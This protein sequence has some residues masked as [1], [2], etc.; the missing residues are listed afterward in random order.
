MF[1]DVHTRVSARDVVTDA[2]IVRP[3]SGRNGPVAIERTGSGSIIKRFAAPHARSREHKYVTALLTRSGCPLR[4]H[5]A[6][7]DEKEPTDDETLAIRLVR[8]AHPLWALDFDHRGW[9]DQVAEDLGRIL[10]WLHLTGPPDWAEAASTIELRRLWLP[11]LDQFEA[12]SLAN[13]QLLRLLQESAAFQEPLIALEQR[14]S[15]NTL[16]HGDLR[17]ANILLSTDEGNGQPKIWLVDWEAAGL[18]DPN[19]DLGAIFADL[20]TRWVTSMP[21]RSDDPAGMVTGAEI[22]LEAIRS[23]ARGML[24]A[25]EATCGIESDRGLAVGYTGVSLITNALTMGDRSS[26]LM[27]HQVLL[28]QLAEHCLTASDDVARTL[29]G[30]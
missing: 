6:E 24:A 18:G 15:S 9:G 1:T 4:R 29:L 22:P 2:V 17:L 28:L 7:I 16:I 14:I 10:A 8:G 27:G 3:L 26:T 11:D 25:Y 12:L 23:F 21:Y 5:V 19:R 13:R 20:L 30:L